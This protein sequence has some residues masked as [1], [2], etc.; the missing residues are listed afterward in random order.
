MLL[1]NR[2]YLLFAIILMY[3]GT[4]PAMADARLYVDSK[5]Q[6]ATVII[7]N[8]KKKFRQGMRLPPGKYDIQV[9]KSGYHAKRQWIRLGKKNKRVKVSL[10]PRAYEVRINTEPTDAKIKIWNIKAKY[11]PGMSL[12]AGRY[13]V[14]VSAP[15]YETVRRWIEVDKGNTVFKFALLAQKTEEK[16]Y[17][18][19]PVGRLVYPAPPTRLS[20]A[21]PNHYALYVDTEPADATVKILNIQPVFS[22]G[23]VLAPGRYH[24]QVSRPG[25]TTRTQWF[26]VVNQDVSLSVHLSLPQQCFT[27]HEAGTSPGS[28]V[29]HHVMLNFYDDYAHAQYSVR[30]T[31][32][33]HSDSFN[34]VGAHKGTEL[35]LLGTVYY[36]NTPAELRSKMRIVNGMLQMDFDGRRLHLQHVACWQQ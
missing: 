21:Q 35:D 36:N 23:M 20:V 32:E 29:Y 34:L 24:L 3:A 27:L 31:P 22:Q 18:E 12:A 1:P 30:Y 14:S 25:Y 15:G 5:P 26:E 8:I 17:P 4:R 6:N 33:G 7:W 2:F 13:N 11:K 9:Q 28:S 16:S 10:K 19:T